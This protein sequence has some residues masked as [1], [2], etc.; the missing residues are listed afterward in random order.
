[1]VYPSA[2]WQQIAAESVLMP[3][4]VRETGDFSLKHFKQLEKL[5]GFPI[6]LYNLEKDEGGLVNISCLLAPDKKLVEGGLPICNLIM[7]TSSHVAFVPNFKRYMKTLFNDRTKTPLEYYHRCQI[8]FFKFK[9]ERELNNHLSNGTRICKKAQPCRMILEKDSFINDTNLLDEMQPDLTVVAYTE[10]LVQDLVG[11]N[12]GDNEDMIE[13]LNL[14]G[15]GSA[16]RLS[17]HV[18]HSVG[19]LLLDHNL[20]KI[21]YKLY[22]GLDVAV[23]F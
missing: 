4:D 18:P 19:V 5:N 15:E 20:K 10:C 23:T 16:N 14:P 6:A 1:M 2:Y 13:G 8:C 21:C 17:K 9:N 22:W 11:N 12:D 3:A 7:I